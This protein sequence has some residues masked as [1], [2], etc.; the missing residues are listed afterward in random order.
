MVISD[1]LKPANLLRP[2]LWFSRPLTL[3]Q[4]NPNPF[5]EFAGWYGMAQKCIWLE[6]PDAVCLSTVDSAGKPDARTVLVKSVSTDGLTFFTNYN[7]PKGQQLAFNNSA[8]MTFFWDALQRQVRVK[9]IVEKISAEESDGYFNSRHPLS[10]AAASVSRQSEVLENADLFK[11]QIREKEKEGVTRPENWGG[12]RLLP[13]QFEFWKAG[14]NRV[15]DRFLY[16]KN[17]SGWK[18]EQLYP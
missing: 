14:A 13:E 6:F 17:N 15:H 10:R 9:G 3:E 11:L 4:L 7:S 1:L 16:T 12:F 2:W 5:I 8:C 18:L